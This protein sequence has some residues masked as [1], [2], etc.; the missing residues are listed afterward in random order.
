MPFTIDDNDFPAN[1]LAQLNVL[2]TIR[3]LIYLYKQLTGNNSWKD[4]P[5]NNI[6]TIN[7]LLQ[8]LNAVDLEELEQRIDQAETNINSIVTN[9]NNLNAT[10]I[11]FAPYNNLT[12]VDV[13]AAISQLY[14]LVVRLNENQSIGGLKRFTDTTE[15]TNPT[16]G[17]RFDGGV[18]IAK[19]LHVSGNITCQTISGSGNWITPTLLNSFSNVS[20][21]FQTFQYRKNAEGLVQFRGSVSRATM[22]NNATAVFNLPVGFRPLGNIYFLA[23]YQTNTGEAAVRLSI[24]TTGDVEWSVPIT[25]PASSTVLNFLFMQLPAFSIQ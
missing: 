7:Q 24:R 9:I 2:D 21:P 11:D 22:P 6:N 20:S 14:D 17:T 1:R 23:P 12:N 15:A 19:N 3:S 8:S 18:G 13:Q 25:T 10:Q 4:L 16:T 5:A